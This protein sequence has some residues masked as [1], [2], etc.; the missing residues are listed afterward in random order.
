MISCSPYTG[1][2]ELGEPFSKDLFAFIDEEEKRNQSDDK[3]SQNSLPVKEDFDWENS[4]VV[5]ESN[6]ENPES[7]SVDANG[8]KAGRKRSKDSGE[9]LFNKSFEL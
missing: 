2:G 5:S 9:F 7:K 6:M 8:D 4:S 3:S 1:I